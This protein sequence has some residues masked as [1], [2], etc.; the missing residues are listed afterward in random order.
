MLIDTSLA[1][2]YAESEWSVGKG[3]LVL[4]IVAIYRCHYYIRHRKW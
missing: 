3:E 1:L 4:A 2:W